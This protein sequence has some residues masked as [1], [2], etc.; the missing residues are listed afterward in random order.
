MCI[1]QGMAPL[2]AAEKQRQYRARRDAD[3]K[4]DRNTS[5]K[6]RRSGEKIG[7]KEGKREC[8]TSVKGRRKHS[9]RN[10]EKG[11]ESRDQ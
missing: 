4:K 3:P 7:R 2:S 5:G 9:E 1:C 6:R 11:R 10:G 8:Q